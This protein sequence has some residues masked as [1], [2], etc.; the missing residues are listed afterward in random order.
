MGRALP[1]TQ[2]FDRQEGTAPKMGK[3]GKT[4]RGRWWRGAGSE[5]LSS[6]CSGQGPGPGSRLAAHRTSGEL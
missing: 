5:P 4:Q 1:Q 3:E 2:T 6:A